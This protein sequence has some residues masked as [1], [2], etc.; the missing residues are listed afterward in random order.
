LQ[1]IIQRLAKAKVIQLFSAVP[2]GSLAWATTSRQNSARAESHR[3]LT[4]HH[5]TYFAHELTKR[6]SSESVDK[7]A[8]ALSDV[9]IHLNPHQIEA[10]LFPFMDATI[11]ALIMA[12]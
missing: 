1:G 5:E 8:S 7:L 6:S 10:A 2:S 9:Q 12:P 3:G 4:P 11:V